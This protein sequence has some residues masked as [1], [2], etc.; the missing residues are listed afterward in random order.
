MIQ[1]VVDSGCDLPDD[2]LRKFSI[3][4]LPHI[5]SVGND[6][7]GDQRNPAQMS[8]F[9]SLSLVDRAHQIVTGP[10][11]VEEIETVL[12]SLV[13]KGYR[14]IVVQTIN[15]INSPTYTNA[16]TAAD[17]LGESPANDAVRIHTIDSHTLFSGQGLLALYTLAQI[18]RGRTGE[19]VKA[20]AEKFRRKIHGYAAIKDVYYVR[21]RARSKNEKSISWFKAVAAKLFKLHP[22]LS[23]H[24]EGSTVTNTVRGY[25]NCTET[26]FQLAIDKIL[27]GELLVP[28]IVVSIAGKLEDLDR[29]RGFKALQEVAEARK[30][31]IYRSVM[32]LSGGINLGPNTVSL[33]L[34]AEN[35]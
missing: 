20:Q 14:D 19:Q 3:P 33:A 27:D 28:T 21:Q 5:V 18:Q 25:G 13:Q 7:F 12:E 2:F 11:P 31:Q 32:S 26:L 1:L 35:P 10:A 17:R 34:A 9:Y 6:T 24:H 4:V 8:H 23:I 30:I 15:S 22:I 16:V 29:V